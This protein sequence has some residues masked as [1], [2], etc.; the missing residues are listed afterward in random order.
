MWV[1][2]LIYSDTQS[3]LKALEF[4]PFKIIL[5]GLTDMLFFWLYN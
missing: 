5:P 2:K 3:D 4:Y 1:S